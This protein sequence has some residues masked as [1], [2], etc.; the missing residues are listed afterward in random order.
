MEGNRRNDHGSYLSVC[1]RIYAAAGY[2]GLRSSEA[3]QEACAF[4][5]DAA[6]TYHA[7]FEGREE[8]DR[9]YLLLNGDARAER[10]HAPHG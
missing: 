6:D 9:D 3:Y 8:A 1:R 4:E 2:A 10:P 5:M 7:F